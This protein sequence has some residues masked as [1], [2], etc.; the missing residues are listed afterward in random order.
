M[1]PDVYFMTI[2]VTIIDHKT[3]TA[4]DITIIPSRCISVAK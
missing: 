4:R 2:I 3:P 1:V